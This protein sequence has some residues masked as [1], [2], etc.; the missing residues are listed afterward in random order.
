MSCRFRI[1][2]FGALLHSVSA[3]CDGNFPARTR[4]PRFE[5][6]IGMRQCTACRS[7]YMVWPSFLAVA[8][9]WWLVTGWGVSLM[10]AHSS[11]RSSCTRLHRQR[12]SPWS[13][14]SL[15]CVGQAGIEALCQSSCRPAKWHALCCAQLQT[16]RPPAC[17]RCQLRLN[18]CGWRDHQW[19]TRTVLFGHRLSQVQGLPHLG[20]RYLP[21]VTGDCR[22]H[23]H[24]ALV[25]HEEA[26]PNGLRVAAFQF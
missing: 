19:C 6:M 2:P 5:S 3:F 12:C 11:R 21:T 9:Q 23:R 13:G 8:L 24:L 20:M 10:R 17:L 4:A 26:A 7:D 18:T 14:A 15:L 16:G 25:Q 22:S 1:L